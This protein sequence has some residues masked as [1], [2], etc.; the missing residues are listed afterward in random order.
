MYIK[1]YREIRANI[2]ELIRSINLPL[3]NRDVET[4]NQTLSVAKEITEKIREINEISN[5]LENSILENGC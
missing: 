2:D 1:N 5:R 4:S 3:N